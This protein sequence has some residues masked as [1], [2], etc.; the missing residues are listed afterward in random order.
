MVIYWMRRW[1]RSSDTGGTAPEVADTA[2]KRNHLEL[3]KILGPNRDNQEKLA[4]IE[5]NL[6]ANLA[7]KDP[8]E[9]P[10]G[11]GGGAP[12]DC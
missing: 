1:G 5:R 9:P 11:G 12:L 3:K 10:E 7:S 4:C 8:P 2:Q 6:S